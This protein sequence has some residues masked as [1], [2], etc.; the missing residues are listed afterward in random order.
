M[1]GCVAQAEGIGDD[2]LLIRQH[3]SLQAVQVS[4]C[5]NFLGQVC[6]YSHHL[7]P[8]LIKLS[9]Q[10]FQSTQLADAVGSPVRPEK[11]DKHQVPIEDS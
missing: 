10:F 6:A 4:I 1:E 2:Q 7:Y 9:A 5:G 11:L 8:T 3:A